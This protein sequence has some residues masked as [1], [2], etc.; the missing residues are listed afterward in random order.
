MK[1]LILIDVQR[2]FLPGGALGISGADAILPVIDRILP[3]FDHVLASQDW[4]PP[5]HVSFA[6][7]QGK[8]VGE[9]VFVNGVEQVLWP[10]HCVQNTMGAELAGGVFR[11]RI[12]AVFYKGTDPEVDSY[13]AFFDNRR[14]RSTGLADYLLKKG[15]SDLYF[16]GLATDYCVLYSVL[17]SLEMGF[18]T[19][20]ILDACRAV[21]LNKGDE[22]RAVEKM[23]SKGAVM[24]LSSEIR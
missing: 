23:R 16:A 21:N 1:T 5:H 7:S 14:K 19:W 2:D 11:N 17:D 8:R 4:H 12:E 24:V 20:V 13:S 3:R 10:V 22:Q 18:R 15:L 6:S 9:T